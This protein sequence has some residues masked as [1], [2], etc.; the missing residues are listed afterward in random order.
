MNLEG[1]LEKLENALSGELDTV[2]LDDGSEVVMTPEKALRGL[3]AAIDVKAGKKDSENLE[4]EI[5]EL[6][7]VK[8]G[9]GKTLDLIKSILQE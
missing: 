5:K 1:R 2:E 8:Q 6:S 4:P 9:Q 3:V 7:K